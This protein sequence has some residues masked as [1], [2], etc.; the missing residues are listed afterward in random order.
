MRIAVFCAHID[1]GELGM[2]ATI[3]RFIREGHDVHYIA[4]SHAD[5]SLPKEYPK[6]QLLIEMNKAM[7]VLGVKPE[8]RHTFDIETRYFFN[9]RQM[10]LQNLHDFKIKYRPDVIFC[11]SI[12]DQH[13]D[14]KVV[15]E[16]VVRCFKTKNVMMFE[17]SWNNYSFRKDVYYEVSIL[18][19]EIK[20]KALSCYKT[21]ARK[22]YMKRAS[23][24]FK[25]LATIRGVDVNLFYAEAFEQVR[26]VHTFKISPLKGLPLIE[27]ESTTIVPNKNIE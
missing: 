26:T 14:H 19:I 8:N 5:I 27:G 7:D 6:G 10:V 11:P 23:E 16:E 18:D 3:S 13:Q 12:N 1:D 15:A 21:Q 4:F 20:I 2:G 17:L 25:G 9:S 22:D 24:Y